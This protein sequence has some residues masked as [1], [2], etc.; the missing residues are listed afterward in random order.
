MNS[1]EK[2]ADLDLP[3]VPGEKVIYATEGIDLLQRSLIIATNKRLLLVKRGIVS[4][5]TSLFY[6]TISLVHFKKSVFIPAVLLKLNNTGKLRI[7]RTRNT[8][9]AKSL[10]SILSNR[11]IIDHDVAMAYRAMDEI[12]EV[13]NKVDSKAKVG[14]P[15]IMGTNMVEVVEAVEEANMAFAE[16][17]RKVENNVI[18]N[19]EAKKAANRELNIER[20][21]KLQAMVRGASKNA[22]NATAAI[23]AH[24]K[25]QRNAQYAD[26]IS[27]ETAAKRLEN[28][29]ISNMYD[30]AM[31]VPH[32]G[33]M[34]ASGIQGFGTIAAHVEGMKALN[35]AAEYLNAPEIVT[36]AVEPVSTAINDY[37]V[38]IARNRLETDR[39]AEQQERLVKNM[40]TFQIRGARAS[41]SKTY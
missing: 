13:G 31:F 8:I 7:I 16:V 34:D 4:A 41:L 12:A 24:R 23:G 20:V 29:S 28:I 33:A 30:S 37:A 38:D 19:S 10:F 25:P 6:N 18:R 35:N 39:A 15:G 3:L 22:F 21:E 14:R 9:T 32:N 27:F 36:K 1:F 40:L 17:V 11:V 5:Y 2:Y 26:W